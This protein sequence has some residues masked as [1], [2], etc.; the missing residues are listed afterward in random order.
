MSSG[1]KSKIAS[2]LYTQEWKRNSKQVMIPNYTFISVVL[3]LGPGLLIFAN[4]VNVKWSILR[5]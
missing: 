1:H 5:S 3:S 2:K 4:S